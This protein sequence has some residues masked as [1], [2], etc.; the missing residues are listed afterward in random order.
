[1]SSSKREGEDNT[2]DFD[3]FEATTTKAD[4][5]VYLSIKFNYENVMKKIEEM[6]GPFSSDE[7]AFYKNEMKN[8]NGEIINVFQ[9]QLV[10]NMFYKYFGDTIS[11]N[12]INVDDYIKL[13]LACKKMLRNN[14]MGFLPWIISGKVNKIVFRKSLNKKEIAEME[15]SQYFHLVEDKYKNKKIMDQILGTIATIITS[16]F[17]VI[18]YENRDINGAPINVETKIIIEEFLMYILLI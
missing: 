3:R 9:R 7:I 5:S 6:W 17:S 4:E 15:S 2:S 11:I 18:D 8:I 10:F 16:S 13:V 12:A 1:M 14:A